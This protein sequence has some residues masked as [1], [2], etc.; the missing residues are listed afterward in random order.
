MGHID[1]DAPIPFG[2]N[3]GKSISE[4]ETSYLIWLSEQEWFQNKYENL[5]ILVEAELSWREK[6]L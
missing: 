6:Y 3:K 1:T 5:L 2:Y 4:L